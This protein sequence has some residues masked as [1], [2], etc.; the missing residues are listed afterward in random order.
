MDDSQVL[1]GMVLMS[2]MNR[3]LL[4][5]NPSLC[6]NFTLTAQQARC[7]AAAD[8]RIAFVYEVPVY[9]GPIIKDTV[10]A[11]RASARACVEQGRREDRLWTWLAQLRQTPPLLCPSSAPCSSSRRS[12][13]CSSRRN[14]QSP[15]HAL[16]LLYGP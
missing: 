7:C 6:T 8:W 14:R 5:Q 2:V 4:R 11:C 10:E 12:R 1:A 13:Q 15:G 9:H 16:C 3:E